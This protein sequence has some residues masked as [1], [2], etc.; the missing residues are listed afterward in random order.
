MAL[1]KTPEEYR[2]LVDTLK[3]KYAI[4]ELGLAK[5]ILGVAILRDGKS[6]VLSQRNYLLNIL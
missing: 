1:C 6:I 5:Y 4:K 3:A 2:W